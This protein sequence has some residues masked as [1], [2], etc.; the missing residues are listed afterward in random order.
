MIFLYAV[1][2][3]LLVGTL[4][5]P[6]R[7]RLQALRVGVL[8]DD[9]SARSVSVGLN[10]VAK[11]LGGPYATQMQASIFNPTGMEIQIDSANIVKLDGSLRHTVPWTRVLA[12]KGDTDYCEIVDGDLPNQF[13]HKPGRW[14][15]AVFEVRFVWVAREIWLSN[16]DGEKQLC[17]SPRWR[18]FVRW[19]LK[20]FP[21]T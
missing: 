19:S 10:I 3:A 14:F 5:Y 18:R 13:Q 16:S 9:H 4:Q 17:S 20:R 2:A 8:A 11:Q 7:R 21:V 15:N 12:G 6:I 1:L